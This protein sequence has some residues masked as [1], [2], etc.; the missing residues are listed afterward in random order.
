MICFKYQAAGNDFILVT[1]PESMAEISTDEV[2]RLC[3]RRY[4]IGADGLIILESSREHDFSMRFFN[5]D[6][7]GGMMCG[8]GGRCIVDLARRSGIPASGKDDSWLFEAPDGIHSGR[9]VASEG[10]KSIVCLSM[11]DIASVDTVELPETEGQDSRAWRMNTGTDHLVIFRDDLDK[12]DVLNEGRRWRYD[13]RFAPKGVNV[14]FVQISA[15]GKPL[16]VRTYEKGVEYETLS[17]GTGI[18][19]SAIAAWMKGD[20]RGKYTLRSTSDTFSVSFSHLSGIF[21][22]VELTGPVELVFQAII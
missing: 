4:G 7:S 20:H 3:D 2:I 16:R 10:N 5:N 22:N 18:I 14:N 12:T 13:S 11:N 19:A 17:C 15:P 1:S 9:I 21:S 8:N 6:G